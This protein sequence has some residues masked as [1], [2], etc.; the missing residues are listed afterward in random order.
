[1]KDLDPNLDVS[2]AGG[3]VCAH[4]PRDEFVELLRDHE[5]RGLSAARCT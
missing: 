3:A 2:G 1:M 5:R 4:H